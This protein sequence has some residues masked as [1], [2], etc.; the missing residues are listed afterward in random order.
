MLRGHIEATTDSLHEYRRVSKELLQWQSMY[1]WH[2]PV[3]RWHK[4]VQSQVGSSFSVS[5]RCDKCIFSLVL[6][7]G[8]DRL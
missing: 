6:S 8:D 1:R 5:G 3:L 7:L 2:P 4:E